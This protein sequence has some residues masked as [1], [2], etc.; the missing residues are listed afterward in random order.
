LG[1]HTLTEMIQEWDTA[2]PGA[3]EPIVEQTPM[4]RAAAPEEIAEAALWLLSNRASFV[5]GTMPTVGG[6]GWI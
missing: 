6:G 1:L 5:T 2:S 4:R 3:V